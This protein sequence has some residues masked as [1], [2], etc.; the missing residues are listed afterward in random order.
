MISKIQNRIHI[1]AVKRDLTG[2]SIDFL[3]YVILSLLIVLLPVNIKSQKGGSRLSGPKGKTKERGANTKINKKDW[4]YER[5]QGDRDKINHKYKL[6][7]LLRKRVEYDLLKKVKEKRLRKQGLLGS[8]KFQVRIVTLKPEDVDKSPEFKENDIM[9]SPL[10]ILDDYHK[11][12]ADEAY[13][14]AV[15]KVYEKMSIYRMNRGLVPILPRSLRMDILFLNKLRIK[16]R[17]CDNDGNCLYIYSLEKRNLRENLEK[18][19]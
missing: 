4:L 9:D 8:S 2:K 3:I 13:F 16:K 12:E 14:Q 7:S 10:R 11:K 15:L 17:I 6:Q 1:S 18:L 19:Y 5:F